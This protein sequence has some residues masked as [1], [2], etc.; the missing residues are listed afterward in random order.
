MAVHPLVPDEHDSPFNA[1]RLKL[2]I[3]LF[4]LCG[5]Y[6]P[7]RPAK[8]YL[9]YLQ[10]YF[11]CK[12]NMDLATLYDYEA[13]LQRYPELCKPIKSYAEAD[14]CVAKMEEAMARSGVT[15][16]PHT[17]ALSLEMEEREEEEVP[18]VEERE[19][20]V[21]KEEVDEA[22]EKKYNELMKG[23][24][25]PSNHHVNLDNMIL[26]MELQHHDG[27][28]KLLLQKGKKVKV[29]SINVSMTEEE[30]QKLVR[31]QEYRKKESQRIKQKTLQLSQTQEM[32]PDTTSVERI[33]NKSIRVAPSNASWKT[34]KAYSYCCLFLT[35]SVHGVPYGDSCLIH[36]RD[37]A[38]LSSDCHE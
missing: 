10:R 13:M 27:S 9:L 22:F 20:V 14:E 19:E 23:T 29:A 35:H 7:A 30:K 2:A 12:S 31:H 34:P 36:L 33:H 18:P 8:I 24:T 38:V 4:S 16:R 6:L 32:L 17:F 28:G 37:S 26:P 5:L 3:H 25:V 11:L 1:F 15:L 21:P